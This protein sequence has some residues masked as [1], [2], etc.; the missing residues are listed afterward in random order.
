MRDNM[1]GYNLLGD[2]DVLEDYE[3]DLID[4]LSNQLFIKQNSV[5]VLT[6]Y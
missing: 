3:L 1:R 2:Q 5:E 4:T 6:Y